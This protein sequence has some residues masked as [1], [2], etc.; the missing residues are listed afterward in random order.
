MATENFVRSKYR[1]LL[2][3]LGLTEDVS[4]NDIID[5]AIKEESRCKELSPLDPAY[6]YFKSL[7]L[8]LEHLADITEKIELGRWDQVA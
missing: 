7:Q 4:S 5:L 8:R 1:F 3:S 2:K 6:E